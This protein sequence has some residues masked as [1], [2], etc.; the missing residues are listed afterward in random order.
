MV[1]GYG[2]GA[3]ANINH[4]DPSDSPF[5]SNKSQVVTTQPENHKSDNTYV[6]TPVVPVM[7]REKKSASVSV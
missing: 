1:P 4:G 2:F 7:L 3:S 6:N 5:K